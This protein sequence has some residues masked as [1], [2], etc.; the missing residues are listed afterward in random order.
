MDYIRTF[1]GGGS[2]SLCKLHIWERTGAPPSQRQATPIGA[3]V[4][5]FTIYDVLT[6]Y[7]SLAPSCEGDS[8]FVV[9]SV[10]AFGPRE[11]KLPHMQSDYLAFQSLSQQLAKMVQSDPKV[12]IQALVDLLC[13]YQGLFVD[14]CS[15]CERVLS[16][17][18]HVPPVGRIW[19]SDRG[20]GVG[21][22]N[23]TDDNSEGNGSTRGGTGS[24]ITIEGASRNEDTGHGRTR[25]KKKIGGRWDPRHVTCMHG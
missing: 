25:W 4:L 16:A 19:V 18:G 14:R 13:S 5:R 11:K 8:T 17:E 9:E 1:N 6:T 7:I 21:I 12:S 20:G 22:E 23:S 24:E 3:V 10:T 15:T 2:G